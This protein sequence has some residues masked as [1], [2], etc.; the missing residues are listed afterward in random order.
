MIEAFAERAG[1]DF[2]V[3]TVINSRREAAHIVAGDFRVAHAEAVRRA[4]EVYRTE[5]PDDLRNGVDL[6]IVNGYPLVADPVL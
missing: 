4:V 6:V 1:L 5:I 2:S 3:N